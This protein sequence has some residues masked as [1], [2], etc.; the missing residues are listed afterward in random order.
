[1]ADAFSKLFRSEIEYEFAFRDP[2]CS[3]SHHRAANAWISH[4]FM[5][6]SPLAYSPA[7]DDVLAIEF[8][9]LVE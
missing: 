6:T 8:I 4:M 1:M 2:P 7:V 3:E 9:V 5:C